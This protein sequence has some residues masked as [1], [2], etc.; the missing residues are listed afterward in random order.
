MKLEL[1]YPVKP[2]K[3]NE[4]GVVPRLLG[5]GFGH[6]GEWYRKNGIN[7]KGHTGIDMGG[8]HGEPIRAAHDGVVI[9]AGGDEKAGFGVSVATEQEYEYEGDKAYYKT[10]YWH[11]PAP[12]CHG[13]QH[14]IPVKVGQRVKAGQVIGYINS[15]GFSTG[16]H[17]HFGLKPITKVGDWYKNIEQDNGYHGAIDPYPYF[18]G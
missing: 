1:W 12:F 5:Q 8:V 14:N 2:R 10:I 13:K 15:T 4:A 17:L 18:N 6:N 7:V 11:M 3:V 9:S 16:D